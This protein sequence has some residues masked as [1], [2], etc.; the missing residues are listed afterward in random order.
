MN[1]KELKQFKGKRVRVEYLD[2][3]NIC[4]D[5]GVLTRINKYSIKLDN[6]RLI[7]LKGFSIEEIK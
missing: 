4:H 7:P 1:P 5:G 3:G 2:W 6:K